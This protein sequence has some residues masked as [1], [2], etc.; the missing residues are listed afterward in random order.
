MPI[1]GNH[2]NFAQNEARN[3]AIHNGNP[4]PPSGNV[5]GQLFFNNVSNELFYWDGTIWQSAKSGAGSSG[6][7][8]G[9]AGGDL[10]GTYPNPAI[11]AGKVTSSHIADGTITDT[12]VAAANK[13]GANDTYSMRRLA[14]TFSQ[15]GRALPANIP[16]N[17]LITNGM[18]AA[19]NG[20][21][22]FNAQKAVGLG[23]PTNASDAATKNYVDGKTPADATT[24]VKG[25]VQLAGDLAGTAASP[26]IAAGV[27]TDAD[28][29]TNNKDGANVTPSLRTLNNTPK[30]G[31]TAGQ[32][33]AAS[34]PLSQMVAPSSP[35]VNLNGTQLYNV[36]DP[37]AAQDAAT[38]QY[39]DN[40]AQGL[41]AK[42]S[43]RAATTTNITLS[44]TQTVDGVALVVGDRVLVKDQPSPI[45]HG[46]Y[47][48]AAGAWT[49]STDMD[50]WAEVPS[51]FVFVEQGT[52]NKDTGWVTM[53]DQGGTL[54]TSGIDWT[55]FSGAGQIIAGEA[56]QKNGNTLDVVAGVGLDTDANQ[57]FIDYNAVTNAML[58]D[59]AVNLAGADVTGTLPVAKGGTNATTAAAARTNLGALGT[60]GAGLTQSGD[61]VDVGAGAGI[62]VNADSV[63]VAT[64]GITST[65]I[66]DNAVQLSSAQISGSLP[67]TK[68]GTGGTDAGT[69]R[70][71]LGAAG[72]YQGLGPA[73]AGTTWV[74]PAA[75]HGFSKYPIVQV[76]NNDVPRVVELPDV[77]IALN[78][79]VT[80]TWG[81][82]VAVNS[83]RVMM[84][85]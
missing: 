48:V 16:L 21:V 83:K 56:L 58:A 8:S 80:I 74:I 51:A 34:T 40:I 72:T 10:T 42:Q 19:M 79:D 36:Q 41:D 30:A 35:G 65:M 2:L 31:T 53:A 50:T 23:E 29:N 69:A 64:K 61:S 82:S 22:D 70:S 43:V 84:V 33:M 49:R 46:I 26:Q 1:L 25:I 5:K 62:A 59:G 55:Q 47:V 3:I 32:A 4:N 75:T 77:T 28:V 17:T 52:V 66:A 44:G 12:D 15:T 68:G 39:V 57:I 9:P 6:P 63:D 54:G 71:S 13:D 38:K 11:G 60:A 7:P 24:S 20:S 45:P 14:Y 27:I 18:L 73:S 78:N 37:T 85:A 76:T 67:L 81:A